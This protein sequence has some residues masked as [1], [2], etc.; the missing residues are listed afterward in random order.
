MPDIEKVILPNAL[1]KKQPKK[2]VVNCILKILHA[3]HKGYQKELG[4]PRIL[5]LNIF[6]REILNV[7]M[8]GRKL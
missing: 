5:K 8:I 3:S 4:L 1:S 7:T 2:D 6:F